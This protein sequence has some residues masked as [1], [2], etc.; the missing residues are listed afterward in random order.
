MRYAILPDRSRLQ[1]EARS[2][3]H[4]VRMETAGLGGYIDAEVCGSEVRL[5]PGARLELAVE[6]LRSGNALLDSELHRRLEVGR[7]PRIEGE[8]R[9]AQALSA[10]RWRLEGELTIHGVRR[11]MTV[12]VTVK[13]GGDRIEL[14]GEKNID[15]RDF[16]LEP[17]KIL[18]LRVD[19]QVRVRAHLVAAP[20][21]TS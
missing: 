19:P 8:L 3:L 9:T 2:S 13:A 21:A 7:Y 10:E 16:G 12:E 20:A 17:P 18:F 4:P 15:M 14:A 6:R 11:S 5:G 1:A